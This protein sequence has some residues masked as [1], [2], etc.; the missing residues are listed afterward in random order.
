[1]AKCHHIR[2]L[3]ADNPLKSIVEVDGYVDVHSASLILAELLGNEDGGFVAGA[4]GA[5]VGVEVDVL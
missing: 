3:D 1:M 4:E 2:L 5:D